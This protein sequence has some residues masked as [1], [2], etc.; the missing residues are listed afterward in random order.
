MLKS[1]LSLYYRIS[2]F[3]IWGEAGGGIHAYNLSILKQS[4]G[5]FKPRLIEPQSGT[6]FTDTGPLGLYVPRS[7]INSYGRLMKSLSTTSH[8]PLPGVGEELEGEGFN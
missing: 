4:D 6:I 8:F 2:S 7:L 5:S 3:T 1:H